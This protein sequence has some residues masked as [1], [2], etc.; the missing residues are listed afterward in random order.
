MITTQEQRSI[1]RGNVQNE[2]NFTIK[3][4]AKA[5]NILSSNLYSNKPLAIIR[6]LCCNAYDSHV[7]AGCADRPIE[8]VLPSRLNGGQMII[9]DFGL[10]LNHEQMISIY[11]KFFE[12][13]KTES[14]DFVGQL[15]LGSKSPFSMFKTFSIEAR[16]DNVKRVYTA[17]LNED[18]I[19][20]IAM[21][22]E[23]A[24]DEGN[25]VSVTMAV[26]NDD[27]E[28]FQQAAKQ[29]LMYFSPKPIVNGVSSFAT[30]SVK[31]G[32]GGSDW[33]IRESEYWAHMNG[34]HVVQGF[35]VYPIDASIVRESGKLSGAARVV[36]SLNLD[37]WLPI[38][39]VD[40]A[41]SREA[42]SYDKRTIENLAVAFERV[43]D[44]MR[45][46]IQA[47]LDTAATAYEAGCKLFK[48][49]NQGE[50]QLRSLFDSMHQHQAFTWNGK[51]ITYKHSVDVSKVK[52]TT[53]CRAQSTG[54]K[55]NYSSRW[56][57]HM[58][59]DERVVSLNS[60]CQV[61][62]DDV[63]KSS[64][65]IIKQFL[66]DTTNGKTTAI[67]LRP[68]KKAEYNQKEI[69]NIVKHLGNAP[70][71]KV[72]ELPYKAS[73]RTSTSKG[74]NKEQRLQFTGFPTNG[75]YNDI[76]RTFS[77]LTWNAVEVDLSLGGF[78]IPIER[79]TALLNGRTCVYLDKIIA[80]SVSLGL[81]TETECE[82]KLFGFNEKEIKAAPAGWVNFFDYVKAQFEQKNLVDVIADAAVHNAM[83]STMSDFNR[84]IGKNWDKL[85]VR[86]VDGKFKN[87]VNK[88][89]AL[90]GNNNIDI[91]TVNTF[92]NYVMGGKTVTVADQ[93]IA[94][95]RNEWQSVMNQHGML[96]MIS[97]WQINAENASVVIDYVNALNIQ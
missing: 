18:G 20:T 60:D 17:Y 86:F 74:R 71:K 35:V 32:I 57:P 7:A 66:E 65:D 49:E 38:G 83:E 87:T 85:E 50:Y 16:K 64:G 48:H 62:I 19:P 39:S 81:I 11:T 82:E 42:L 56:E 27:M 93:R 37:F 69:N 54:R 68:T 13:T 80:A 29:A 25:G 31:H 26:K 4:S 9:K 34:P 14:N 46:V 67:I 6:E 96:G 53:I 75:R 79:F 84:Y 21:M 40:V 61:I 73:G 94:D 10:G 3:A 76:R 88:I 45:A 92:V 23:V 52:H 90:N 1:V 63:V 77:R 15:G 41:P 22:S 2:H 70:V 47:D 28:K 59:A 95:I 5:F 91:N 97:W 12:S 8:V 89:M 36:S 44:E 33:K 30:Y 24:T 72:S 78:Y 58:G 55:L 43:A 51:P